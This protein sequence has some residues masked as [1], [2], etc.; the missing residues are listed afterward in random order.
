[1]HAFVWTISRGN[2]GI[3][4]LDFCPCRKVPALIWVVR[5]A[6]IAFSS[7]RSGC[8]IQ[9]LFNRTDSKTKSSISQNGVQE[10]TLLLLLQ[11]FG[12]LRDAMSVRQQVFCYGAMKMPGIVQP[13]KLWSGPGLG[14]GVTGIWNGRV[15]RESTEKKSRCGGN[16][17]K[18]V[19]KS[20]NG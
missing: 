1:M 12:S 11:P 8:I 3:H 15:N 4:S 7:E 2:W 14:L 16:G 9:G 20:R 6:K 18:S 19:Q 17:Q 10:S 5:R 13:R